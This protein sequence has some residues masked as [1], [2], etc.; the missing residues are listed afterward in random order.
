MTTE[1]IKIYSSLFLHSLEINVLLGW[2]EEERQH[3]QKV[4]MDISIHFLTPPA[5]CQTDELSDTNCYDFI[6]KSIDQHTNSREFRLIEHL[7]QSL[8]SHLKPLLPGPILLSLR[9]KKNPS[10]KNL[11]GG[12]SFSYG[13][14]PWLF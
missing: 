7:G 10:I 5:A 6:T 13:D 4:L 1:K 14:E 8:Y 3:S 2:L 9:I 11:S 12:V